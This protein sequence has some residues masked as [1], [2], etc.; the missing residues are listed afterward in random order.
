[1][2]VKRARFVLAVVSSANRPSL[3]W[4]R[5]SLRLASAPDLVLFACAVALAL[6]GF[7]TFLAPLMFQG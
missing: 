2:I 1:M 7:V 4:L 3:H 6:D 5:H